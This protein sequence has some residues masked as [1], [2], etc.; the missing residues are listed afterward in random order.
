MNTSSNECYPK[1]SNS[2]AQA[3]TITFQGNASNQRQQDAFLFLDN[4]YQE[5]LGIT[6][7]RAVESPFCLAVSDG[8]ASSN[9]SQYC[10]KAVV[11][12]IGQS[13]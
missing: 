8:V 2:I 4:W 10:S 9:Y 11:K 13:H 3:C 7:V 1:S 12:A 6:E 5:A